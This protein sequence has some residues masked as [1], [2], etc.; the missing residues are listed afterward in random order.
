MAESND[1]RP[2]KEVLTRNLEELLQ[3]LRVLQTGVQILTG[4]L[5]TVP[6]SQR[7][8][9]LSDTEV[10]I[11]L[12]VLSGS[13]LVT[14]LILAPVAFHRVLFRQ[15]ERWWLV[16][17]ANVM[18]RAGLI[19]FAFV[20]SGV[21]LLVFSIVISLTAGLIAGAVALAVLAL[22]WLVIPSLRTSLRAH[23]A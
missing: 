4:F 14:G 17:A 11:Y 19:L 22:L 18:T 10:T 3:E 13:V 2:D 8:A 21:L 15:H 6:F 12:A 5:L 7:F 1:K 16:E 20:S 23:R 9:E